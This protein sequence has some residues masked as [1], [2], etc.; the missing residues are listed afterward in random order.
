MD[1]EDMAGKIDE[2]GDD[3][4]K[5]DRWVQKDWGLETKDKKDA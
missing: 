4:G 5:M 1:S 2:S 3:E